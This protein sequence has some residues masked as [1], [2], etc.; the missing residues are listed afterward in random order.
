MADLTPVETIR[1]IYAAV[2]RSDLETVIGLL[3]SDIVLHQSSAL[4]FAGD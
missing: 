4:P 3:D 1:A 2:A